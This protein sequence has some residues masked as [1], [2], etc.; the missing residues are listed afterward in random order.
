MLWKWYKGINL[1][2]LGSIFLIN[3]LNFLKTRVL[4][5]RAFETNFTNFTLQYSNIIPSRCD[6]VYYVLP[7]KISNF[8]SAT[9]PAYSFCLK[10]AFSLASFCTKI[11]TVRQVNELSRQGL[12]RDRSNLA[13]IYWIS[14]S[15]FE[16]YNH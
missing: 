3:S 4:D 15:V 8:F 5:F 10:I 12:L 1:I 9:K 6:S 16:R 11:T 13:I 7:A 14:H 2:G